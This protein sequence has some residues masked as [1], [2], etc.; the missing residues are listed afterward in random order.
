MLRP[1]HERFND[2]DFANFDTLH[3]KR[4]RLRDVC[5]M[6]YWDEVLQRMGRSPR[7][8]MLLAAE[9]DVVWLVC[10]M[11]EETLNEHLTDDDIHY[12]SACGVRWDDYYG[13]LCLYV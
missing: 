1:L 5:G 11:S 10:D 13:G 6:L 8:T 2:A 9:H 3:A 12:L 4:H 7:H